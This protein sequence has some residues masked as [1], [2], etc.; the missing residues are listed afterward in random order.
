ME[1]SRG[2]YHRTHK[3]IRQQFKD[4]YNQ[5]FIAMYER[6]KNMFLNRKKKR[7]LSANQKEFN[8][9]DNAA[10]SPHRELAA[11]ELI[12]NADELHII[13]DTAIRSR[14]TNI[15]PESE[16]ILQ[17]L[18]RPATSANNAAKFFGTKKQESEKTMPACHL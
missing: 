10:N 16:R 11:K 14:L 8:T 15:L 1:L 6:N 17:K 7:D 2:S 4:E 18:S 5:K 9:S 12:Y 13:E 3:T